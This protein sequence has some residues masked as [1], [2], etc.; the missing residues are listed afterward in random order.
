MYQALFLHASYVQAMK[1]GDVTRLYIPVLFFF[2]LLQGGA[3]VDGLVVATSALNTRSN[4]FIC[5]YIERVTSRNRTNH[6]ASRCEGLMRV[7]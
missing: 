6:F 4:N 2:C 3:D 5:T 7:V 1:A